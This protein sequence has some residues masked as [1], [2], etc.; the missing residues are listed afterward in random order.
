MIIKVF[1]EI[2][3][4][5]LPLV[6]GKGLN[7]GLLVKAGFR[8][9]DGFCVTTQSYKMALGDSSR[10]P[11]ELPEGMAR[12]IL[13][14]YSNLGRGRVA[15]RSSATAEDLP[16]ASF[17]GQQD[18]FLNVRGNDDLLKAIANCW[19]SLWSD[20]AV[21][22]RR[23]QGIDDDRV[24]MAVVVQKMLDSDASG[25]MFS[26]SPGHEAHLM[27]EASWGLGEA[28]VSGK[29]TPDSFTVDRNS[30]QIVNRTIS[31]KELMIAEGGEVEVQPEKQNIPS[32]TDEQIT[33]LA[34][35]GLE[36]ENFYSTPQDIEWALVG[37]E[38]YVLQSR[39]I[40][41]RGTSDELSRLREEE[42]EK[43]QSMAEET[44]T[45]WCGFNLSET[46][47]APLPMTWAIISKFMSGRGGF[48]MTYRDLG[49]LPGK[50]V[51]EKGVV[52]LICGRSYF[53]LSREARLYFDEFPFEHNFQKL[54]E[55]P[56]SASYPQPTVNIRRTTAKF[57]LKFPYYVYK[58]IAAEG[59]I[60]RLRKSYDDTLKNE[61]IPEYRK[62]IDEQKRI[63][64]GKLSD[65]EIISKLNEWLDKVL[66]DHAKDG[67]KATII[68]GRSY[69]NLDM[70]LKKC[71]G[72]DGRNML[73]DLTVGLEGDM[74]VET[75]RKL[76]EV[77]H[78][79]LEMQDF[80][81][82]Y[83]HRAAGEYE[84]AQPR[85]REDTEFV[86]SMVDM[87]REHEELN[88][89]AQFRTQKERREKAE[90]NL[91][92]RL[93][94]GKARAYSKSILTEVQYV[95][96][97]LPYRETAKFYLMMGYELIRNALLELGRR[98][99]ES[100]DGIFYLTPEEL[101]EL[102][103]G[104][105]FSQKIEDRR[106]KRDKLLSIELPD[107]IFSDSLYQIG[108]P[109]LPESSQELDGTAI[110][111]GVATGTARV[112]LKPPNRAEDTGTGYIL[113]CPSTDPGWAPLFPGARGLVMERGGVLSHGAI[114]AREY[115]IPAV[116]NI[117][118]AT[119]IIADGQQIKV[120]GNKGKVLV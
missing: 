37:E 25:V 110:S 66:R 10:P 17:A 92:K 96:R 55:N 81:R 100:V 86:Q 112:L 40:T 39:P 33:Q 11:A 99:L 95:Q 29:V 108:D 75:N 6:G 71:F 26:I 9:P 102:I 119:R 5:D 73:E 106:D 98:H 35:L 72:E 52:D 7:L 15:V 79:Q 60:K 101:P 54:K 50:E 48:G 53:N 120:D 89:E 22:Y 59:K 105:D 47:P 27:I 34:R 76:W 16:D 23:Q 20:R 57:W 31:S 28:I 19:A 58:M 38:L 44:G 107:V 90:S 70:S 65:A 51:D 8:V 117:A 24:L 45:V 18:T 61:I 118:G 84:L 21:A 116:A 104:A 87:F 3:E 97:Y 82:D 91:R 2:Q 103:S 43:L 109:P 41:V 83:G 64:L 13:D 4:T 12:E 80:L 93:L 1:K 114:V 94:E 113:V 69:S 88:P 56:A 67:L 32:L 74:T 36:I 49:F 42:I 68:A 85:W 115:G 62:Y 111:S 77:A 78:G 30:L 14:A 46:L 63:E